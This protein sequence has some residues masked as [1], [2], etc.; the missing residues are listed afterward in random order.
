M[1]ARARRNRE[2]WE[3]H[4]R[5]ATVAELGERY[6][7]RR[8]HITQILVREKAQMDALEDMPEKPR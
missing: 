3:A 2:I 7:L 1:N 4:L 5:G 6:D 8:E